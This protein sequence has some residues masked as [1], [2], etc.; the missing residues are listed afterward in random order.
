MIS[1][2]FA[3]FHSM[4]PRRRSAFFLLFYELRRNDQSAILTSYLAGD[5]RHSVKREIKLIEKRFFMAAVRGGRNMEHFN[6]ARALFM[7]IS[8]AR[9]A[10]ADP[11]DLRHAETEM[12]TD[13][14][15]F[16]QF[17]YNAV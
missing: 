16:S 13:F 5:C 9:R 12:Q 17:E 4:R 11:I 8:L 15:K 6:Y 1:S 14:R 3:Y 10:E 7:G 2:C